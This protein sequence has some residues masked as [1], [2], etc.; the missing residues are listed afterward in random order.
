MHAPFCNFYNFVGLDVNKCRT[1]ESMKDNTIDAYQV[2]GVE[3]NK[4][5]EVGG[6]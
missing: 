4:E 2:Q 6:Q 5:P 1:L 3:E